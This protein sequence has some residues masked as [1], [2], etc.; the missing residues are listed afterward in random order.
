MNIQSLRLAMVALSR[1]L[2]K[3][4]ISFACNTSAATSFFIA[5]IR[6]LN[7]SGLSAFLLLRALPAAALAPVEHSHG[8]QVRI[9]AACLAGRS[10]VHP[11]AM[12][13]LQ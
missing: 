1:Y 7:D 2:N 10:G 6:L 13:R 9:S 12:L 3:L 4:P 5:S 11:F 8:L